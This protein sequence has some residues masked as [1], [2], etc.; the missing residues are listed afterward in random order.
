MNM[1]VGMV[2]GENRPFPPDIRV[3][4]EIVALC[5]AGHRVT[6]LANRIPETANLKE[7]I[8][9]QS[10]L[11][12]RK[13]ITDNRSKIKRAINAFC[14]QQTIWK[15]PLKEFVESERPDI[16]HVHDF[17]MVPVVLS[18]A[19]K[20]KIPVIAD[21]HENM[22]AAIRAYR[23]GMTAWQRF[24]SAI[25]Y[26]YHLIRWHEK[27]ALRRCA[28]VI[29]VVPEASE[30][31]YRYGLTPDQVVVVSN[32]EDE[33]TF[34]FRPEEADRSILEKY[35]PYWVASYI[36]GIGPHRGLDTALNAVPYV[37]SEIPNFL[38]LIVGATD[39]DLKQ[40][41]PIIDRNDI[42]RNVEVK[43]WQPFAKV[44]SYV[45][46]SDV[47]LVPHNDFEHTHTT[48]PHKL[49]QYMICC[50]PVLV[51]SCRPLARIVNETKSGVV[52]VVNDSRNL[53]D[54]L[55]WMKNNPD[56]LKDMG[57]CGEQAAFGKYA[58]RHDAKRLTQMY[59]ILEEATRKKKIPLPASTTRR[60]RS[61][62][63]S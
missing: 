27:R 10:A 34:R 41:Q 14:M 22:P 25:I 28:K 55:I 1:H 36:G 31:L 33:T 19:D 20:Y 43:G 9:N 5:A 26:N 63:T 54:K 61:Q 29:V 2:Y 38:L 18:V 56:H 45:M 52:F 24:Q 59:M 60:V 49:F 3:E 37:R 30:R 42:G 21:L 47:C 48:V 57:S 46:A 7:N 51:S 6:V 11:V 13:T 35:K 12:V 17:I 58:W 32:T 23:A 50:K 15:E 4:K 8:F 62:A 44:N 16:L 53:A 39:Y 40:I